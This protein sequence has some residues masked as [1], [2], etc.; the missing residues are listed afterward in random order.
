MF[1]L[2]FYTQYEI[3]LEK[4]TDKKLK[5]L[6]EEYLWQQWQVEMVYKS[7]QHAKDIY[8]FTLRKETK[9][10]LDKY[11]NLQLTGA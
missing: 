9:S 8:K 6:I 11:L 2:I 4:R 7:A 3:K 10:L 1:V 5:G